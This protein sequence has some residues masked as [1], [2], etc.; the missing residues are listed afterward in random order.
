[1]NF[2]SYLILL[3]PANLVTAVADI[4]AGMAIVSFP[5][6]KEGG[7]LILASIC[8]YGGGVVLNDYFDRNIDSIERPERPIPS[9]KV[10]AHHALYLGIFLFCLGLLFSFLYSEISFIISILIV[11]FVITYNRFAKHHLVLGPIVMGLCR[12]L[13]LVL[14]MTILKS[15][16]YSLVSLSVL[17]IFYIAAITSISQNEVFGGGKI[18]FYVAGFLYLAVFCSQTIY[19]IYNHTF[20]FT[21]PFITLHSLILF[22]TLWRVIQNPSPTLIG[23]SVKMGVLTLILLNVSFSAASGVMPITILI[24]FLL[25]LSFLIAKYFAVT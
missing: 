3:R 18:R 12:G 19:S 17:P 21:L 4:L 9:G 20:L 10:S 6:V 7:L 11:V 16:P 25:P 23:K 24:L 2:K 13:N 22:P 15:I 5:W 1:M 8:L 14:G